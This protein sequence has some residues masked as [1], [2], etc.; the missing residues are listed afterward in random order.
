MISGPAIDLGLC[1]AALSALCLSQSRHHLEAF[2]V[3]PGRGR[4]VT[5]RLAG[6]A[7]IGLSLAVAGYREGWALGPVQWVGALTASALGIVLLST[8][9]PSAVS[10]IGVVAL[11]AAG[12]CIAVT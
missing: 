3:R 11:A 8:Y 7:C 5:L 1:V 4:V 2:G 6:W 9:Y 10:R 12:A